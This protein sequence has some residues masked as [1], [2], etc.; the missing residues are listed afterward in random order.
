MAGSLSAQAVR[1]I[2]RAMQAYAEELGARIRS[3]PFGS[4]V[5]Q[6][7]ALEASRQIVLR[8]SDNLRLSLESVVGNNRRLSF[9]HVQ[10]IWV[11]ASME[12]AQ[13]LGVPDALMGAVRAPPVLMMGAFE[14]VGGARNW[15]TLIQSYLKN[16]VDDANNV[17]RLALL[18]GVGPE[19]LAK[20][21][22]PYVQG[23]E[24]LEEAFGDLE[25][26]NISQITDPRL[27]NAARKMNHNAKRIAFSEIHNARG[28]AEIQLYA[29]DPMVDAVYWRLSPFRG[30]GGPD[31]CD[32]LA[33]SDTYGL[34]AG[35]YP[36]TKVPLPP[37]PWDRCE[38]VPRVRP[39][40][41]FGDPKP[42]PRRRLSSG[43]TFPRNGITQ[44]VAARIDEQAARVLAESESRLP[45][46]ALERL[47]AG[48]PRQVGAVAREADELEDLIA[49]LEMVAQESGAPRVLSGT[50]DLIPDRF[51]NAPH[52]TVVVRSKY[53]TISVVR[54]EGV[55][56]ER[57]KATRKNGETVGTF[58]KAPSAADAL[59]TPKNQDA[60]I[61][62]HRSADT[63]WTWI[64]DDPLVAQ[65]VVGPGGT[66]IEAKSARDL[67]RRYLIEKPNLSD[68]E[69]AALVGK[70]FPNVKVK[71]KNVSWQR[72]HVIN[73][74]PAPP[75]VPPPG[76]VT[77]P[78][79]PRRGRMTPK[80]FLQDLFEKEPNVGVLEAL[81]RVK[82]MFPEWKGT[83]R[84]VTRIRN[85]KLLEIQGRTAGRRNLRR[86]GSAGSA[87]SVK[88]LDVSRSAK[89]RDANSFM[90][91]LA[92]QLN[93]DDIRYAV[94]EMDVDLL[95][96]NW[97]LG[98]YTASMRRIRLSRE[99][100]TRVRDFFNG[101]RE[102]LNY[103]GVHTMVHEMHHAASPSRLSLDYHEI[104]G[105]VTEEG[106]V[107]L[108]SRRA[109][110]RAFFG[111][112]DW[113]RV[114]SY[115]GRTVFSSYPNEVAMYEWLAREY[116]EELL[117]NL[118]ATTTGRMRRTLI[119]NTVSDKLQ[120]WV[121][122]NVENPFSV[123]LEHD[124][125]W[126][127]IYQLQEK[128]T[129]WDG[130]PAAPLE[131]FDREV[132]REVF[133]RVFHRVVKLKPVAAT[134]LSGLTPVETAAWIRITG[135][136][137]DTTATRAELLASG[138]FTRRRL[139]ELVDQGILRYN[140][141]TQIYWVTQKPD[142]GFMN[143]INRAMRE[144]EDD[145]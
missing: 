23:S 138:S 10:E 81:S 130:V 75:P 89:Q 82:A 129:K 131:F 40:R 95:D 102:P 71:P 137:I 3:L 43:F 133:A 108:Y 32:A 125:L 9:E 126:N 17:V 134:A 44:Q 67:I 70:E 36:V 98:D 15:K 123:D 31:V 50:S 7:R 47:A 48:T 39:K 117:D 113:K 61:S 93:V 142:P 6:A 122:D 14:N 65:P 94:L 12:A 2:D 120:R 63:T 106:L 116:G 62:G 30:S 18:Q 54:S 72:R 11:N 5:A 83:M 38:R 128:G 141:K 79:K 28:E 69:I 16:A 127:V 58:K 42:N 22:R 56:F 66:I 13:T 41:K 99:T 139:Q 80:K 110:A 92:T 19:T 132:V 104:W 87:E 109:M 96:R 74:P 73:A 114:P 77:A 136:A 135:R 119:N 140:E 60:F 68:H 55:P 64:P 107:E 29:A 57:Y 118:W 84:R 112:D 20:R 8:A 49:R 105:K 51:P 45:V 4:P 90:E 53:G 26:L 76:G 143:V 59:R 111:V 33:Y 97:V 88:G 121:N 103:R 21:L 124:D 86:T 52:G 34:G 27:R 100:S 78:P 91:D 144:T 1:D 85:V 25:G 35:V 46:N 24:S 101:A 145:D 37:H 115:I